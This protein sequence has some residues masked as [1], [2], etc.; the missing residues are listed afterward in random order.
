MLAVAL[1]LG[2]VSPALAA[3]TTPPTITTPKVAFIKG[4]KATTS[5]APIRIYWSGEDDWSGIERYQFQQ[6]V[7]GGAWANVTLSKLTAT[8]VQRTVWTNHEYRYRV[9]AKDVAGNWSKYKYTGPAFRLF[10]YQETST[11]FAWS[12]TWYRVAV[13]GALGGYSRYSNEKVASVRF[14]F[15]GRAVAWIGMTCAYCGNASV[16]VDGKYM[17]KIDTYAGTSNGTQNP[18][19]VIYQRPWA[20]RGNH[21]VEIVPERTFLHPR[22]YVD[23][24]IILVPAS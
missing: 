9:R 21:V 4:T 14:S 6:S 11:K 1:T 20:A 15:T 19:L 10:V 18:R 13:D 17:T 24:M 22:V 23:A 2:L 8:S 3:D 5:S 16:Y 7:D 12:G